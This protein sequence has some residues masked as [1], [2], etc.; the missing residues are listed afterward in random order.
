MGL[1]GDLKDD[2]VGL[3]RDPT[4]EQ[5]IL[6]TAAVAIAIADRALYF[7]EFPFVVRTTAAVGVGFIV[8]FLV[9]YLYTGQ[10]VPPDGNVDD[11][12]EPEE[13]VDEL[14]P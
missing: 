5:K 7:V 13:Y 2:V 14:D 9:S 12:E 10:L 1:L 8:M 11:D 3:V 4:D 6:V